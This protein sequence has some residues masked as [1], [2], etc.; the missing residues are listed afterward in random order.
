MLVIRHQLLKTILPV[1]VGLAMFS[2]PGVASAEVGVGD[3]TG[4]WVK[5]HASIPAS[6]RVATGLSFTVGAA[7]TANGAHALPYRGTVAVGVEYLK[8]RRMIGGKPVV[9]VA[10]AGTAGSDSS[11]KVRLPSASVKRLRALALKSHRTDALVRIDFQF[12][13]V[14]L[15]SSKTLVPSSPWRIC[16]A[17]AWA[18]VPIASG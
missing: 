5:L 16:A 6:V 15:G 7:S 2:N 18:R 12:P 13:L 11:V 3:D 10:V 1:I 4:T 17:Q 9:T 8:T 14:N